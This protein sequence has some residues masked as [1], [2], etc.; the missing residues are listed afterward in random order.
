MCTQAWEEEA[1]LRCLP[2]LC[3]DLSPGGQGHAQGSSP[4]NYL[5]WLFTAA[6]RESAPHL[7]KIQEYPAKSLAARKYWLIGGRLL[8]S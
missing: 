7:Q 5:L 4:L 1:A 2:W 8:Q 3:P 6:Q